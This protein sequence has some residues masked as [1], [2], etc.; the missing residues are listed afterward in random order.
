MS[1]GPSVAAILALGARARMRGYMETRAI[2]L[3]ASDDKEKDRDTR[4]LALDR[5]G[6]FLSLAKAA[7][8][9]AEAYDAAD[10]TQTNQTQGE[11]RWPSQWMT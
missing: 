11:A 7:R 10:L 1:D 3:A 4:L 9:E 2:C 8:Y 5:A 6:L